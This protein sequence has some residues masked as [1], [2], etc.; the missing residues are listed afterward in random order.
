MKTLY[1]N[2]LQKRNLDEFVYFIFF[3]IFNNILQ[4]RVHTRGN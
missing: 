4:L 3:I 2:K 1:F